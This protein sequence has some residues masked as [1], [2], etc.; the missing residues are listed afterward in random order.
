MSNKCNCDN[1]RLYKPMMVTIRDQISEGHS[2]EDLE[3]ME[4]DAR[5]IAIEEKLKSFEDDFLAL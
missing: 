5:L 2:E 4:L 3:M 1:C